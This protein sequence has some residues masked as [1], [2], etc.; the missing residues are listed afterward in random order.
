[1]NTGNRRRPDFV[2]FILI[3]SLALL[4]GCG[5][6]GGSSPQT[7]YFVDGPVE[8]LS[9][10][11][12]TQS[13]Q[14]G[15]DGSFASLQRETVEL[16]VGDILI[17]QATGAPTISP[18]D[19]AGIT[20]PQTGV[21]VRRALNRIG[22]R[23]SALEHA[24][25]IAAFL[26]TIDQDGNPT[27]G[28]QIPNQMHTLAAGATID[29]NQSWNT[30]PWDF[31]LRKLV[32]AG[33]GAG[34]WGGIRL[35]AGRRFG[36]RIAIHGPRMPQVEQLFHVTRIELLPWL[37]VKAPRDECQMIIQLIPLCTQVN[38]VEIADPLGS[39]Q[40]VYGSFDDGKHLGRDRLPLRLQA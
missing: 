28:I 10:S 39:D 36:P 19:L 12:A 18:F 23:G 33:R 30:F 3:V 40:G 7:G 16:Y 25:N 11:T 15:V 37:F 13:G 1:M 22:Y 27:N 20:P 35:K 21:D 38:S 34:L 6:G 5:S 31:S 2:G 17:G 32:A 29:F 24:A 8:G 4:V 26:Q 14:T 9:Y